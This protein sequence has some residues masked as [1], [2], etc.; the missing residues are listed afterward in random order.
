MNSSASP[1]TLRRELR[2]VLSGVVQ[3]AQLSPASDSLNPSISACSAALRM[4]SFPVAS[5][6]HY[7]L[8]LRTRVLLLRSVNSSA[9]SSTDKGLR[10]RPVRLD[11]DTASARMSSSFSFRGRL[12]G[13]S[14]NPEGGPSAGEGPPAGP[15]Y[16]TRIHYGRGACHLRAAS[17][18]SACNPLGHVPV[19]DPGSSRINS[20]CSN[21]TVKPQPVEP[22][23][24]LRPAITT[25]ATNTR[26]VHT[27]VITTW[28][29]VTPMTDTNEHGRLRPATDG[30]QRS[31][32]GQRHRSTGSPDRAYK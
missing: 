9:A 2:I 19:V 22:V 5:A 8:D 7:F 25:P 32:P 31:Y 27:Q 1:G 23:P 26:R 10:P 24:G 30:D 17:V 14:C 28:S 3:A 16:A 20:G 4:A 18:A 6:M 13:S 21:A 15:A 12:P 29:L 11:A